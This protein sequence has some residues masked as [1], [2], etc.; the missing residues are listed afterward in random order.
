[1]VI[2]GV[3][4]GFKARFFIY[5]DGKIISLEEAY[6]EKI[7]S[8]DELLIIKNRNEQYIESAYDYYIIDDSRISEIKKILMSMIY[9]FDIETYKMLINQIYECFDITY[10]NQQF[11]DR[12][13]E[14]LKILEH[15]SCD[16][17]SI[18]EYACQ[19]CISV[20]RL[21]H[22]FS[23]QVG[24]TLKSYLTL[25]QLERVFQD[26]LIGKRITAAALDA[27]FDSPSHLAA[28][29]KRMMGLPARSIIKDSEF[30]KV[31]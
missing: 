24:I 20:S 3:D 11:D 28:T 31:Y 10:S 19:L 25:H 17:H 9:I 18:E 26:L 29:V 15:C 1:M 12:I 5:T 27:G 14:F 23:E 7:I 13:L 22:L 6:D 30:L 16:E 2:G 8:G 4:F 21:S